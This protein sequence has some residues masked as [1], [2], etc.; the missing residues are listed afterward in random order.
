MGQHK[1]IKINTIA[2][3]P[4][5]GESVKSS[6]SEDFTGGGHNNKKDYIKLI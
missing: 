1:N 4:L 3:S 6:V 5:V 2:H